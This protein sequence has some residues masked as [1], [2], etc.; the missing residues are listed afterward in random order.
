MRRCNTQCA[1]DMSCKNG[2]YSLVFTNIYMETHHFPLYMGYKGCWIVDI[3]S[4][5]LESGAQWG[6]H[7]MAVGI[8]GMVQ[9]GLLRLASS[10]LFSSLLDSKCTT[11]T[12]SPFRTTP[13]SSDMDE[14]FG[15]EESKYK[16]R[17]F[18]IFRLIII[19]WSMHPKVSFH[20]MCLDLC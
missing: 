8:R 11:S 18:P 4:H 6:S 17:S 12:T 2:E 3:T 13:M 15:L 14:P 19:L 10:H 5:L 20:S 1:V 16:H 7:I 9:S